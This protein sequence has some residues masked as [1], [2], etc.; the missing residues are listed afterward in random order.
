MKIY[1]V[2]KPKVET[3][4]SVTE[5][6][7]DKKIDYDYLFRLKNNESFNIV[8]RGLNS[9]NAILSTDSNL[10]LLVTEDSNLCHMG[11]RSTTTEIIRQNSLLAKAK[12]SKSMKTL[13]SNNLKCINCKSDQ[14]QL[15]PVVVIITYAKFLGFHEKVSDIDYLNEL[16]KSGLRDNVSIIL[17]NMDLVDTE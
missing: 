2:T 11:V 14:L 4:K 12:R 17:I 5:I 3:D 8:T 13:F 1:G 10:N 7:R 9:N 15:K 16:E 6:L